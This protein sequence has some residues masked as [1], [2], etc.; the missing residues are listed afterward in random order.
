MPLVITS[1]MTKGILYYSD[2]GKL[3]SLFELIAKPGT[4]NAKWLEQQYAQ[5]KILPLEATRGNAALLKALIVLNER[6]AFQKQNRSYQRFQKQGK[7]AFRCD[8]GF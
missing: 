8:C 5:K 4:T 1:V 6:P 7:Q 3:S 2:N